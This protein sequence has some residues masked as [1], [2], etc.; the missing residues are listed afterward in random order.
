[1]A[2]SITKIF[3]MAAV[4]LA[5]ATHTLPAWAQSA[6]LDEAFN[7]YQ[8]LNE[9]GKYGEAVPFAQAFLELAKTEFGETHSI[10][11][12]G[13]TI[14][15]FLYRDQAR[16]AEAEPLFKRAL[17]INEMVFGPDHPLCRSRT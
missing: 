3:L 6:E 2:K 15:G 11:A 5:V 12:S 1:M 10:Y 8:A 4:L 14:L 16:Y 9:Q 13:L 7:Q 17:A